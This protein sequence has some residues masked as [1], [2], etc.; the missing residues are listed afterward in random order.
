M[1][2]GHSPSVLFSPRRDAEQGGVGF[3]AWL[4]LITCQH[5][6]KFKKKNAQWARFGKALSLSGAN[7]WGRG[8][9][10]CT[11]F[12]EYLSEHISEHEKYSPRQCKKQDSAFMFWISAPTLAAATDF[13]GCWHSTAVPAELIAQRGCSNNSLPRG[14]TLVSSGLRALWGLNLVLWSNGR[15]HCAEKCKALLQDS[16]GP[17]LTP[18]PAATKQTDSVPNRIYFRSCT[19]LPYT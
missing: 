18:T 14:K 7:G 5:Y 13:W 16:V 3:A 10:F 11:L 17:L 4:C 9:C 8:L 1:A 6:P 12:T 15:H 19:S 2:T